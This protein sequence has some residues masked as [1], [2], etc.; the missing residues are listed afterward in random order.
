MECSDSKTCTRCETGR[1]LEDGICTGCSKNL[2]LRCDESTGTCA[3][4]KSGFY[5]ESDGKTCSPCATGCAECS[6]PGACLQ[7]DA[8]KHTRIEPVNGK[9]YCDQFNGWYPDDASG[10]VDCKCL[11]DWLTVDGDCTTCQTVFQGCS[12]CGKINSN[13]TDVFTGGI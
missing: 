6:G 1:L 4:C 8:I 5:M 9:C 12:S 11:S 13:D 7:C 3:R 10:G 2:C